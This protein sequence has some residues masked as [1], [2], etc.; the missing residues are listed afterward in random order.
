MASKIDN[1]FFF[2]ERA[3][4]LRAHR[5]QVLAGNIAN[6]DTPHYKARDFD[7]TTALEEALSGRDENSLS[8][9]L[10]N[11]RHLPG[12]AGEGDLNLLYR[13][14]TQDSADGNTV[15]MDIERMQ[16]TDN[17]IR[18]EAGLT[19]ITHQVKLLQAS[20]QAQ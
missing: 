17:A 19:F 18:Y 6:A 7:F 20:M 1:A 13:V 15:E 16:F 5:Q 3:L 9:R 2:Q 8:L 11:T 12:S 10:T 14:P 4:G